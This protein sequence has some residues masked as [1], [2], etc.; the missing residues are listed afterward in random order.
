MTHEGEN[1]SWWKIPV[2]QEINYD[3]KVEKYSSGGSKKYG[4]EKGERKKQQDQT[5]I[6]EPT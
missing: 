4:M 5:L 1:H 3:F 6:N 2:L